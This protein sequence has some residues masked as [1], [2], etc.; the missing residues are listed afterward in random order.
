M[1]GCSASD[2]DAA[3]RFVFFQLHLSGR[4]FMPLWPVQGRK[5]GFKKPFANKPQAQ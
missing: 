4:F 1:D 5:S 2:V 3:E